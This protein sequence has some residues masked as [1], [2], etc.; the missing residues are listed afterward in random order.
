METLQRIYAEA[1]RKTEAFK[2]DAPMRCPMCSVPMIIIIPVTNVEPKLW[3]AV[4]KHEGCR[5]YMKAT[6]ILDLI[7]LDAI[8]HHIAIADMKADQSMREAAT[9]RILMDV[10]VK[11]TGAHVIEVLRRACRTITSEGPSAALEEA[12]ED[13]VGYSRHMASEI[14]QVNKAADMLAAA[15]QIALDATEGND[16]RAMFLART[17]LRAAIDIHKEVRNG[18]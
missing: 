16:A 12:L 17:R 18:R 6:S 3:T 8:G 10:V 4:C 9:T 2:V 13:A 14:V 15:A 5:L 11:D 7:F 1:E